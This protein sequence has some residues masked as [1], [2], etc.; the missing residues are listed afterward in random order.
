MLPESWPDGE[1]PGLHM[2]Y[3]SAPEGGW[4]ETVNGQEGNNADSCIIDSTFLP[5]SYII[6]H[7]PQDFRTGFGFLMSRIGLLGLAS[8]YE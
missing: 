1:T 3:K 4:G 2:C 6:T 5:R 8:E 7:S